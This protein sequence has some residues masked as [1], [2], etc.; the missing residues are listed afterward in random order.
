M[1]DPGRPPVLR[2]RYGRPLVG[3]FVKSASHHNVEVLGHTGLDFI[4][5]DAEHAPLGLET[6]DLMALACRAAAMPMLVRVP[7]I[8]PTLIG[9]C[10]DLGVQGIVVPHVRS[11]A[12]AA[13]AVAGCRF[14]PGRGFSPSTRA[15]DYG[16]LGRA[17]YLRDVLENTTLWAQ[18]EDREA[19]AQLDMIAAEDGVDCLFIGQV[20]LALSLGIEDMRDA[21][22]AAAVRDVA[23]AAR[24]HGKQAAIFIGDISEAPARLGEGYNCFACGSDQSILMREAGRIRDAFD[25]ATG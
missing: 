6:L 11:A 16:R 12:D 20:D 22:L 17:H 21:T 2:K 14:G 3:T 1:R 23:L 7:E 24:R 4:I 8:A 25:T 5:A 13:K 15:G 9:A 19:L 10:L 18:I